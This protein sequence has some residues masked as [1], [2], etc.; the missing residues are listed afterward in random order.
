MILIELPPT[1][2]RISIAAVMVILPDFTST[3]MLPDLTVVASF[4]VIVLV[5]LPS[6]VWVLS[7]LISIS[8]L[9]VSMVKK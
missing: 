2:S 4:P 8:W 1:L 3:V 5:C 7:V 9:P 6:M